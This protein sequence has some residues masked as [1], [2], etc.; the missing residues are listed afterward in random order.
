VILGAAGVGLVVLRNAAARRGELAVLRAVGVPSQQVLLYLVVEYV[1]V[2]LAGLTAGVVPALVAV[3]PAMR[4][5]G[6]G[7]PV[8]TMAAIIAAMAISGLLGTL[9]AVLAA[10]RMPLI[11]A[12]RGE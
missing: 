5:L 7:I 3:Q 2:L 10:T 6:Q 1:Y 8:G 9:A 11:E 4:N 12:L